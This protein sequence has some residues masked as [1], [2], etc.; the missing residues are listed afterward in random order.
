ME[1]DPEKI[2]NCCQESRGHHKR[3]SVA[4][5]GKEIP[6]YPSISQEPTKDPLSFSSL[7]GTR[8][9]APERLHA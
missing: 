2:T 1:G 3:G 4:N 7:P 9:P 5:V 6:G 8:E